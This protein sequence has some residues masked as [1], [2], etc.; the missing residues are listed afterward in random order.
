MVDAGYKT[1]GNDP[2]IA[3]RNAPGF[4]WKE[5][6]SFGSIQ[7]R[8]DLWLGA[9]SAESARVFYMEP[10]KKKLS[11][12]ERL[13]IV[14]NNATLVINIHD[15]I[16]GVRNGVVGRTIPVTGRGRGN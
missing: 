7:G 16:Y 5:M 12:G 11:L 3:A 2:I 10:E 4:F 8:T 15:L 9:L 6:P 14:P 1:L 13:E